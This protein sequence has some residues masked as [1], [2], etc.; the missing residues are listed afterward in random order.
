MSINANSSHFKKPHVEA[1]KPQENQENV[2]TTGVI[3]SNQTNQAQLFTASD[4]SASS[5]SSSSG[6][7]SSGGSFS[8]IG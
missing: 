7:S 6:G 8:A 4:T 2:E 5:S 1:Q 3:A